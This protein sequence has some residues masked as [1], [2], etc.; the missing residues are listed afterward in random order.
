MGYY[1][2][3]V[4]APQWLGI[5]SLV[6]YEYEDCLGYSQYLLFMTSYSGFA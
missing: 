4:R 5:V 6:Q 1:G 3:H 2:P